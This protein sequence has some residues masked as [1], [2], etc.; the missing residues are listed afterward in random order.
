LSPYTATFN[1]QTDDDGP[2]LTANPCRGKFW[3]GSLEK[4]RNERWSVSMAWATLLSAAGSPTPRGFLL[5][6]GHNSFNWR[7][8]SLS[9]STGRYPTAPS[10]R[11]NSAPARNT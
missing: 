1:W 11:K 8:L 5:R 9:F 6:S 3:L 2:S 10:P 4:N 7:I